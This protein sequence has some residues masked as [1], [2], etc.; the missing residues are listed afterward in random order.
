MGHIPGALNIP[1]ENLG[2]RL[3]QLG[4]EMDRPMAIVCRSDIRSHKAAALLARHGYTHLHVV[5]NG[6]SAWNRH[7]YPVEH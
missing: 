2:E 6:M 4:A 1:L 3:E 5:R 7:G